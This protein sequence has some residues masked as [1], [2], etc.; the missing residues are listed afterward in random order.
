M[1]F[2]FRTVIA[3]LMAVFAIS[4][5]ATSAASA[6]LAQK[7]GVCKSVG[8]GQGSYTDSKCREAQTGGAF[9][10]VAPTKKTFHFT[11]GTFLLN[12]N[13]GYFGVITCQQ[14]KGEGEL[15][16]T[17]TV[18][19]VTISFSECSIVAGGH[20]CSFGP[21]TTYK[22]KGQTGEIAKAEAAS[23]VGIL[24]EPETGSRIAIFEK[25][26]CSPEGIIQ[27]KIA[28]EMV[29]VEG[30]E[31]KL[32]FERN[33]E[34]QKIKNFETSAD[35]NAKPELF[36]VG[37]QLTWESTEALKFEESLTLGATI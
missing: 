33:K 17:T 22:L 31:F 12:N 10:I 2:R 6:D 1:R 9:E 27:G 16:S 35:T 23:E 11:S 25:T 4:A 34:N 14:T 30:T 18:S 13:G 32:V 7:L 28:G 24:L 21:F 8:V 5:L 36:L 19:S 29:G 37:F 3:A 26:P 20:K 15:S